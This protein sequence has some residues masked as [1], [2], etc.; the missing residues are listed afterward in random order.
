MK[1]VSPRTCHSPVDH[2]WRCRT[3]SRHFGRRAPPRR[4]SRRSGS[5]SWMQHCLYSFAAR[6]PEAVVGKWTRPE[7]C[8]KGFWR[9]EVA[10]SSNKCHYLVKFAVRRFALC[11]VGMTTPLFD[12]PLGT[13]GFEFVE[14][15]SRDPQ[16]LSSLFSAMGFT[17][18]SRHRSKNVLRYKQG[19][20]NFILNMEP[21]GQAAEFRGAHGPSI[22]AM[23]F[24]V[25]DAAQ[26]LKL[27]LERGA[28]EVKGS[29]GPMELN[30]P[31]IEGI[32]GSHLYL[33]DR[34][35]ANAI[36]DVDFVP[37]RA[38]AQDGAGN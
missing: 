37:L 21:R 8:R 6:V 12:N 24:R 17:A 25:R 2:Y 20:I 1:D 13:D 31:A 26:A 32:G 28:R 9:K 11:G 35:G 7:R 19:G 4:R 38:A 23:A 15:T 34:Y 16:A 33:I 14:F 29:I 27:A 30:I 18:V 3:A 22:N 10:K 5:F 36:Y